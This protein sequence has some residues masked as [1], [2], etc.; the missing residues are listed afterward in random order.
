MSMSPPE[1]WYARAARE[2]ATGSGSQQILGIF[3]FFEGFSGLKTL[4]VRFCVRKNRQTPSSLGKIWKDW[5]YFCTLGRN[6][7]KILTNGFR[8]MQD[9]WHK[10]RE[11]L[12]CLN[13]KTVAN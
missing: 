10:F 13:E 6:L 1:T 9:S 4:F 3:H 7:T 12:T 5:S 8:N 11:K 2:T